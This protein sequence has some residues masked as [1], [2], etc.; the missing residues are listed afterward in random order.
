MVALVQRV[1]EASV[2][3]N[4][5]ITAAIGPGLLIL[6]GVHRNDTGSEIPWLARKCVRLRIFPDDNGLMN[7]S[8]LDTGGECL[9]VSQSTL[10]GSTAKGNRPSFVEAARPRIA[11]KRYMEFI[12]TLARELGRP[13][14]SGVFG[15]QMR[16]RLL[17]DGP[18]TLWIEQTP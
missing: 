9:V 15:A 10:Y 4:G 8:L 17:N 5:A 6:L 7:R 18:V 2:E 11:Q 12:A 16:I 13:V 14:A 1:A 3:V